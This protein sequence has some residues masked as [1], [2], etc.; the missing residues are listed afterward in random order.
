MPRRRHGDGCV[1]IIKFL[2]MLSLVNY[3]RT[4]CS[5]ICL[6]LI[7]LEEINTAVKFLTIIIL[8]HIIDIS[9]LE[10]RYCV[11]YILKIRNGTPWTS[12]HD[13]LF[14]RATPVAKQC[15]KM[16]LLYY[17]IQK[18]LYQYQRLHNSSVNEWYNLSILVLNHVKVVKSLGTRV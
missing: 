5:Y 14:Y 7:Y 13:I 1:S 15:S 17:I 2:K 10:Y 9:F 16:Y 11:I 8:N 6:V 12:S 18:K 4:H 3:K